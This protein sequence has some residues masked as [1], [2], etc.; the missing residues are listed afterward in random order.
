[1]RNSRRAHIAFG[2]LTLMA[3]ASAYALSAGSTPA[4]AGPGS[5]VAASGTG[6]RQR[7]PARFALAPRTIEAL[8]GQV[9][10][11][12]GRLLPALAG[13]LVRLEGRFRGQWRRLATSRTGPR[14]GFVVRYAAGD[15]GEHRLRVLFSGNRRE[16]LAKARAGTLTVFSPTVASWYDDGGSTAC[17]FHAYYGVAN[18]SLPCGTKVAFHYNGRTVTATVDD[19]GP[20]VP[21]RDWDLN[22]NTAGALGFGGVDTVWASIR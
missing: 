6:S 7:L 15:T 1:M 13:S 2:V 3:P 11:V 21:G 16:S 8:G 20:F 4:Y 19:R 18:K 14:G 17:G 9:V 10:H 12:R 5:N 22:Q